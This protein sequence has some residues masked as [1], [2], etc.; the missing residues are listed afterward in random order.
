ML[1][2]IIS[3]V[4]N[5]MK[6]L[7]LTD[8]FDAFEFTQGNITTYNTITING[9]IHK[10]FYGSDYEL[11]PFYGLEYT[12]WEHIKP[13]FLGQI[14]GKYTPVSFKIVFRANK[15]LA[16]SV[17]S[18]VSPSVADNIKSLILNIKY[19]EN[20]LIIT[21]GISEISFSMD[22][23]VE[24]IWDKRVREILIKNEIG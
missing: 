19:D 18:E 1:S 10:E 14:K 16:Q 15:D 5:C 17:L 2:Q 12:P 8:T 13:L 20:G 11:S 21:T 4:K 6:Q 24:E 9:Q 23:T 22:K 3:D 7:L